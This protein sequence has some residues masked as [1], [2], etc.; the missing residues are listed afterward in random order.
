[1]ISELS[2]ILQALPYLVFLLD[3][4][5]EIV[6]TIPTRKLENN[7]IWQDLTIAKLQDKDYLPSLQAHISQVFDRN[8]TVSVHYCLDRGEKTPAGDRHK[9]FI[10]DISPL[11]DNNILWIARDSAVE[12]YLD[13]EST[14]SDPALRQS[15]TPLQMVGSHTDHHTVV[16]E[17]KKTEAL[18][19]KAKAE[20]ELHVA[21]RTEELA[22]S[23]QQLQWELAEHS[24]TEA[25]LRD[26]E[27]QYRTLIENF[28]QGAVFLFDR[29]FC[30]TIADGMRLQALGI[31]REQLEGRIVWNVLPEEIAEK[32]FPS[33]E[34]ALR[35]ETTTTELKYRDRI[36]Y[37]QALPVRNERGEIFAGMAVMQEITERK[38]NEAIL[39]ESQRQWQNFRESIPL[40]V[41]G[42]DL[43]GQVNY[44]NAYFSK[45]TGYQ[46]EECI[47]QNWFSS[48]LPS[49]S[50]TSTRQDFAA[51]IEGCQPLRYQHPLLTR[52]GEERM[53]MWNHTVMKNPQGKAIGTLSIGED[54][55]ERNAIERMKD[56]FISVVS[57][58]LRTPLTSIH[59][60]LNLLSSGLVDLTS[61]KGERIIQIAAE[62][63]E[64]LV[65]LV[66]DILE[67]ERLESGKFKLDKKLVNT[68]TLIALAI[69]QM[70]VMAHREGVLFEIDAE[71][72]QFTADR[73]RIFQ[74]LTNLLSNA[75]KFS[76]RGSTI[77][78]SAKALTLEAE[79]ATI[80]FTVKDE[81]RGIPP[82]KIE[83]IFERFHQVDASDSRKKGGTGLGLTICRSI[84]EQ[85]GGQI[86]VESECDRG[87]CFYF[88]L[89]ITDY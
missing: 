26:S 65:R 47:G 61:K 67:L 36:Y 23:N 3:R 43:Q 34:D 40:L 27:Q 83:E 70:Q 38:R 84:V 44:L 31:Y 37:H 68:V 11:S 45:V 89:P 75:I 86:W 28:P 20:L 63:V 5:G 12:C 39:K 69:E 88:Q 51:L 49:A 18:L 78:L 29:H 1:M 22:K 59:G 4:R 7:A 46:K 14:T 81:G 10:A 56:E 30:Y 80:L 9:C 32:V 48:F 50:Q 73:D 71:K 72:I 60:A 42:L 52:S 54:I 25:K 77:F 6:R 41:V 17:L 87:S 79:N 57:H 15:E 24:I 8:E 53:I 62:N 58:E 16:Q 64:R 19:L 2:D 21:Q 66:N 33:Y 13:V 82:E 55:T 85:H 76:D 35:G 74:V